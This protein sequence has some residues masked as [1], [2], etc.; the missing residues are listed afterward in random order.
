MQG[1][2]TRWTFDPQRTHRAVLQQQGRVVLDAEANEQAEITA[3]HDETRMLDI[4]G[5]CGGPEPTDGTVGPFAIVDLATEP[6]LD[7]SGTAWTNL[8]IG[9]GRYYVDGVLAEA[10]AL[11]TPP[12][13][14]LVTDQPPTP[15][16]PLVLTDQPFLPSI[17]TDLGLPEPDP[18]AVPVGGRIAFYLDVWQHHVTADEDPS[19]LESALGGPDTSTRSQTVWQVRWTRLEKNQG[20]ADVRDV[21]LGTNPSVM[22]ASVEAPDP[23]DDTCR[24]TSAGG[25]QR[26]EN[27]LY[28]VQVHDK[29]KTGATRILWSRE[30]GS[31]VAAVTGIV[32]ITSGKALTLDRDGRDE[33]LSFHDGDLV[34]VTSEDRVLRGLPGYLGHAGPPTSSDD[35]AGVTLPIT[36]L[37]GAPSSYAAL[38]RH[39]VARRWE[40]D[41][42]IAV[43]SGTPIALESGI[44]V[45]FR[46]HDAPRTGD[47]W[48][49]PARTVRLAYGLSQVSGTIEWPPG[50][51]GTALDVPALGTTH[52]VAPLAVVLRTA[53]GWSLESDCRSLFPPLT[54][55]VTIDLV[56]GDGQEAMPGAALPEQV[57]VVVRNGDIPVVGAYVHAAARSVAPS[58]PGG[59]VTSHSDPSITGTEIVARTGDDGVAAFDWTL[60]PAGD[61]TQT[62]TVQRLEV[63]GL[64]SPPVPEEGIDVE[65]VATARLSVASQVSWTS[66]QD[67]TGFAGVT[68]VAQALDTL[69]QTRTL[70]LLGGD[71]QEV[72]DDGVTLPRPVR[73]SVT[74][75]CGAVAGAVLTV[76]PDDG[77]IAAA[78]VAGQ[79]APV[80]LV[81]ETT[82][83]TDAHGV[84]ELW[85]AP[86]FKDRKASTLTI[87]LEKPNGSDDTRETPSVRVTASLDSGGGA[88]R[89]PGLHIEKLEIGDG[90]A[91]ENDTDVTGEQLAQGIVIDLSGPVAPASVEGKP[92]VHVFLELPWPDAVSAQAWGVQGIGFQQIEVAGTA[93]PAD[94]DR[95][96]RWHATDQASGWLSDTL[97]QALGRLKTREVVGRFVVDGWAIVAAEDESMHLNGHADAVVDGVRT[98][99]RLP[100]DDEVTGGRFEQWFRLVQTRR[101]FVPDVANMTRAAA[102]KA[103]AEAGLEAPQIVTEAIAGIAKNRVHAVDPPP[104]TPVEPGMPIRLTLSN[105]LG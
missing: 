77:G 53:D 37:D 22:R 23:M 60:D 18:T 98:A 13:D 66:A 17:G 64:N 85:W 1:D 12:T 102:L 61:T 59:T 72:P 21:V 81:A 84:A 82:V 28:R 33:E 69:T 93:L 56:G 58:T 10:F 34:E 35:A 104:G 8:R 36:W 86:I 90:F 41:G 76:T 16:E 3:Y 43:V 15:P 97:W 96:I 42:P 101:R 78:V 70:A 38:G 31:V 51:P 100:T 14:P 57:R 32:D 6:P 4:V 95:R 9:T 75:P 79:P 94:G 99:L 87:A 47:H 25:Y 89:R 103:F 46:L 52:H 27:Q 54:A 92:V 29:D 105:G 49:V 2:F 50:G 80:P 30:N 7:W 71:G 11:P 62:L 45:Q 91:F 26:L 44:S 63:T 88:A 83:T 5:P 73:V 55:M 40:G 39:V 67:C 24:I 74:S 20:C 48:L 68:T 19:L 65:V